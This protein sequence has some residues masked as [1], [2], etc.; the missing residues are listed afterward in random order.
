MGRTRCSHDKH[1]L[2]R[3][4]LDGCGVGGDPVRVLQGRL[5]A[6]DSMPTQEQSCVRACTAKI[7]VGCGRGM[8]G[9]GTC[10]MPM[11]AWAWKGRPEA[12]SSRGTSCGHLMWE[13]HAFK[14]YI[15]V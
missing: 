3:Q 6:P 10:H 8:E 13:T 15:K 2:G 4:G 7:R 1:V 14:R 9:E 11:L 5:H 12:G